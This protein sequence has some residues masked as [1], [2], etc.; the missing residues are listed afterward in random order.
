MVGCS[1]HRKN[2]M[3]DGN[4]GGIRGGKKVVMKGTK[5]RTEGGNKGRIYGIRI[6]VLELKRVDLRGVNKLQWIVSY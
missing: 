6:M 4:E 1:Q 3:T 5:G 2:K